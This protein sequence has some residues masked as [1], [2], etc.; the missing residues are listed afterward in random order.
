[1]ARRAVAAAGFGALIA[2]AAAVLRRLLAP[3][4]PLFA[5]QSS[6]G[7]SSKKDDKSSKKDD[8]KK[9]GGGDGEEDK[10]AKKGK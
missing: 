1:M 9:K 5:P 10:K 8:K 3:G 7:S 2:G 4:L 6:S